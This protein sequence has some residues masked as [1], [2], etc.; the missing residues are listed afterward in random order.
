MSRKKKVTMQDIA[1]RLGISKVTVSKALN[2]K[3]GVGEQL[4]EKIQLIAYETG[5]IISNSKKDKKEF[6]KNIAICLNERFADEETSFYL[7]CYQ[8]LS[9]ELTQSGYLSNLFTINNKNKNEV[10]QLLV[11]NNIYGVI[12]LGAFSKSFVAEMKHLNIPSIFMDFY[13]IDSEIDCIVTENIY[14][15]YA[16]TNHLLEYGHREIGFVGTIYSTSSIQDRFL[17]YC[18]SL[19]EH[20][21]PINKEWILD[22]RDEES[23]EVQIKLPQIMPTAFVCNCDD[24]AYY[25]V[26]LLLEQGYQ[27]PDDISIVSFDNDIYAELCIPKLTTVAVNIEL[28]ARKAAALIIEKVENSEEIR[29]GVIFVDGKIIY[30]DSVKRI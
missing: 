22:D 1:D 21:I 25:F 2:G 26:K 9:F 20:H 5:Y 24:T 13:D 14:S 18:R 11:K 16:L 6:P 3:D 7:R 15:T 27:V 29:H 12:L 17:G 23:Q 19:I 10:I 8:H 4:K 30:R 28:M